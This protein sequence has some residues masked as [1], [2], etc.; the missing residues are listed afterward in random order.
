MRLLRSK[1]GLPWL[2]RTL[3]LWLSLFL[4][5]RKPHLGNG[6]PRPEGSMCLDDMD[7]ERV[8]DT[9][10]L[11]LTANLTAWFVWQE[12]E[13]RM[14]RQLH[15]QN[16]LVLGAGVLSPCLAF[17]LTAEG[18]QQ[19]NV[20]MTGS[21]LRGNGGRKI[22][23]PLPQPMRRHTHPCGWCCPC[24]VSCSHTQR[25]TWHMASV[26]WGEGS[27]QVSKLWHWSQRHL[28]GFSEGIQTKLFI[29]CNGNLLEESVIAHYSSPAHLS[30]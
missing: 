17:L 23:M 10:G 2:C 3:T 6:Y 28:A 26:W 15:V 29:T 11:C 1:R 16:Q 27:H 21:Y 24:K 9:T 22:C 4:W 20:T 8:S 25:C 7:R 30:V 13:G 14:Q 19:E 5:K 12:L 18:F